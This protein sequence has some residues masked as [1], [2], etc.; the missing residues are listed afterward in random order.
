MLQ[1]YADGSG[2]MAREAEKTAKSLE[3]SLNRLSN[4]WTDTVENVLNADDLTT[5]V[6]GLNGILN[7]INFLTE[8][9]GTLGTIGLGAGIFAGIKNVGRTKMYVLN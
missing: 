7:V 1:Q 8:K 4:T 3:G 5:I 2:S 9:L 6:D